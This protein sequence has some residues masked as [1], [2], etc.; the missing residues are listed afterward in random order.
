MKALSSTL[1]E[2]TIPEP[3]PFKKYTVKFQAVL[4]QQQQLSEEWRVAQGSPNDVDGE[5]TAGKEIESVGQNQRC[6]PDQ[7]TLDASEDGFHNFYKVQNNAPEEVITNR[8]SI[9]WVV[10]AQ[11]FGHQKNPSD[12]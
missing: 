4:Q 10:T 7:T 1:S 9:W 3:C 5:D 2:T 12:S 11:T 8:R 6:E